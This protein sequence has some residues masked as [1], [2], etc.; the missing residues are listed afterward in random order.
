MQT[1]TAITEMTKDE[2][3]QTIIRERHA[4]GLSV[5][6]ASQQSDIAQPTWSRFENGKRNLTWEVLF[7]MAE[8]VGITV[9]IK[10]EAK[11]KKK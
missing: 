1:L 8:A 2:L 11:R 7:A 6:K 9:S 10:T 5:L 4:K 3:L